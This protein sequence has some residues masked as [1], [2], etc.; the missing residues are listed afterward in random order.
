M[1]VSSNPLDTYQ[2]F[3]Q[4]VQDVLLAAQ[5]GEFDQI[6]DLTESYRAQSETIGA[7]D[8]AHLGALS[9]PEKKALADLI[10]AIMRDQA[11]VQEMGNSRLDHLRVLFRQSS[12]EQ[13]LV[14]LYR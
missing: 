6:T 12:Q 10:A 14:D 9:P 1:S 7:I 5:T 11:V 3:A 13:R 8:P 2:R 4:L